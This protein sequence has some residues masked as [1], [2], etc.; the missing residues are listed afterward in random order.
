MFAV[1]YHWK[2][3]RGKTHGRGRRTEH[4]HEPTE[5]ARKDA[6]SEGEDERERHEPTEGQIDRRDTPATYTALTVDRKDL[7]EAPPADGVI[8]AGYDQ[9]DGITKAVGIT[10]P[11]DALPDQIPGVPNVPVAAMV[12]GAAPATVPAEN[13]PLPDQIPGTPNVPAV[14]VTDGSAATGQHSASTAVSPDV[15][16]VTQ[17]PR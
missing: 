15:V 6:G 5:H 14:V 8:G 2:M 10:L 17:L 16:Q 3:S 11:P 13:A 1:R 7:E 12:V 9:Q 4:A